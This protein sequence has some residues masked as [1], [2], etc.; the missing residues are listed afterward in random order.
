[1]LQHLREALIDKLGKK[2]ES[3]S[4]NFSYFH[5]DEQREQEPHC[6]IQWTDTKKVEVIAQKYIRLPPSQDPEINVTYNIVID[7][8]RRH[9]TVLAA[10]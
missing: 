2:K 3:I 1:M 5:L 4:N 10:G 9:G 7:G 6:T 8:V